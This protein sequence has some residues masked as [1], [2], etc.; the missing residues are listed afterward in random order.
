MKIL[1]ILILFISTALAKS[2]L[3]EKYDNLSK[4]S[5]FVVKLNDKSYDDLINNPERDFSVA[6]TLTAM[7]ERMKCLPCHKF[8]PEFSSVA[9]HTKKSSNKDNIIFASLDFM[10]GQSVFQ[11]MQLNT[12]PSLFYHPA[13]TSKSVLYDFNRQGFLAERIVDFIN[14]NSEFNYT[15]KRPIDHTKTLQLLFVLAI[16]TILAKRYWNS[17]TKP[18]ILSKWSWAT[19]TLTTIVVMT[20]GYM[21]NQIRKPPQ[22]VMTKQGAQYFANGVTTQYRVE[23]IIISSIYTLLAVSIVVLSTLVPKIDNP[24][25]QR[26]AVYLWTFILMITFSVLVYIFRMKQPSRLFSSSYISFTHTTTVYPFRLFF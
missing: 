17:L 22:M 24:S 18:F 23:T 26:V 11:R 14:A 9:K 8:Q 20:S 2:S 16:V 6:V 19:V 12:A 13:H 3:L 15:Y 5:D 4:K 10:D 1:N 7:D 21:W 25:R